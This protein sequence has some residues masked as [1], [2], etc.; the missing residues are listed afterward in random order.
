M[1]AAKQD[2]AFRG[3]GTATFGAA[4]VKHSSA[5][6]KLFAATPWQGNDRLR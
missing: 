3:K 2:N 5:L 1:A 4:K 6:A